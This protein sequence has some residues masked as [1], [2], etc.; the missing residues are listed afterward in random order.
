MQVSIP[1]QVVNNIHI[2]G[3]QARGWPDRYQLQCVTLGPDLKPNES[4]LVGV[5]NEYETEKKT[6]PGFYHAICGVTNREGKLGF[7][8]QEVRPVDK[9]HLPK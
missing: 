1:I 6:E 4:T 9:A 8:V 3:N 5:L 2:P 7:R